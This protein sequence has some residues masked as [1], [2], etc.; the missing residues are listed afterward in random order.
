MSQFPIIAVT[1]ATGHLGR[2]VV[3]A[4]L[5]KGVPAGNIVALVRDPARASEFA[6][7]GVQVRQADYAQPE[8]LSAA[9]AGVERVLLISGT[10]MQNR[11][12]Q[13]RNVIGAA[14]DAGVKLIAYTSILNADTTAMLLAA[15]HQA[16]EAALRESG[17]PYTLLRNG[18]YVENY[19]GNL[20]QTL[21]HGVLVGAGGSGQLTPAPRRDYAEAAA[22]V[23]TE[24][25]HDNAT[26]ELGG[27]T[28]VT[29]AQLADEISRQTGQPYA[30]VNQSVPEYTATLTG[31]GLPAG[32][33][34]M[35]ADSD[36]GIARGELS[37]A[38][39]DLRRLIGRPTTP[40][41]D[42]VAASLPR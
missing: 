4:L 29:L 40:L 36:A 31:L 25:G 12:E 26:Y 22:T 24:G 9:L 28:P 10:D 23:L 6:A 33:A 3:Q 30:Y 13:H 16:T 18:W 11:V 35:F 27:D 21:P 19:T 5:D 38:S 34:A 14:K 2:H 41:P 20:A 17:V 8:S 32:A 42:A 39:G 7:Q 1:G 37:T 15:D